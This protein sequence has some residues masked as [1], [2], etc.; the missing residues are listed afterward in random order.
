MLGNHHHQR[1]AEQIRRE[2]PE[3]DEPKAERLVAIFIEG[4]KARANPTANAPG[5]T[6][7]SYFRT[8]RAIV[9]H[10]VHVA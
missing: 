8:G 1:I 7:K 4:E 9:A 2:F 10:V 3:I 6:A 5:L